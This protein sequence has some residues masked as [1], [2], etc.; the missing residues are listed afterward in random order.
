MMIAFLL[1]GLISAISMIRTLLLVRCSRAAFA[2]NRAQYQI[3]THAHLWFVREHWTWRLKIGIYLC[4]SREYF[5]FLAGLEK[6]I[7]ALQHK[8]P[9]L[10]RLHQSMVIIMFYRSQIWFFVQLSQTDQI[11]EAIVNQMLKF[12][13]PQNAI[14]SICFYHFHVCHVIHR[15]N[16]NNNKNARER[17]AKKKIYSN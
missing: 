12:Y 15:H 5:D 14:G 9:I 2:A 17:E 11:N 4:V 6:V 10:T 1:R 13:K 8:Y 16:N 7:W 3:Q